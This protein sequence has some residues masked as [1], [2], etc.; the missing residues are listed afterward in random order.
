MSKMFIPLTE[1]V[2]GSSRELHI[3]DPNNL[4]YSTNIMFLNINH[5]PV[6]NK[7]RTMD[8][9]Q[10]Y[11]IFINV[12]SSQTFRY[13]LIII[14]LMKALPLL[15][16]CFNVMTSLDYSDRLEMYLSEGVSSW[17]ELLS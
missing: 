9:V 12:L 17:Y 13:Y 8:N 15:S 10:K 16:L 4:S 11:Y 1:E 3:E 6:L 5:H 2:I 7:N 14:R